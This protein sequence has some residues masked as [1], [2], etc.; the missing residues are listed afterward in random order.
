[1]TDGKIYINEISNPEIINR[2]IVINTENLLVHQKLLWP[3][4]RYTVTITCNLKKK[5]NPFEQVVLEL[6][7]SVTCDSERISNMTGINI[8]MVK[9][10]QQILKTKAFL[11]DAKKITEDGN[12]VLKQDEENIEEHFF[13]VYQEAYTGELLQVIEEATQ[14]NLNSGEIWEHRAINVQLYDSDSKQNEKTKEETDNTKENIRHFY[15]SPSK[16]TVG[17]ETNENQLIYAIR[18]PSYADAMCKSSV[19]PEK[20]INLI[21]GLRLHGKI[22][23]E[24]VSGIRINS[25]CD[26]VLVLT[27]YGIDNTNTRRD[28]LT[29]GFDKEWSPTMAKALSMV[30]EFDNKYLMKIRKEAETNSID[31]SSKNDSEK[32]KELKNRWWFNAQIKNRLVR[33]CDI[34]ENYKIDTIGNKTDVKYLYNNSKELIVNL[35]EVLQYAFCQAGKD[36][37]RYAA[38]RNEIESFVDNYYIKNQSLRNLKDCGFELDDKEILKRLPSSAEN[39]KKSFDDENSIALWCCV[40]F[41]ALECKQNDTRETHVLKKLSSQNPL[42]I[43]TILRIDE[44]RNAYQ[45]T[46]SNSKPLNDEEVQTYY[47]GTVKIISVLLPKK[48][49]DP[50]SGILVNVKDTE[51]KKTNSAYTEKLYKAHNK[52]Q[53][54]FGRQVFSMIP[55]DVFSELENTQMYFDEDEIDGQLYFSLSIILQSLFFKL[56]L[57]QP[58]EYKSLYEKECEEIKKRVLDEAKKLGFKAESN[59]FDKLLRTAPNRIRNTYMR[60]KDITLGASCITWL[61]TAER[62]EKAKIARR[63]PELLQ[64]TNRLVELRGHN[65]KSD[66]VCTKEELLHLRE[67]VFLFVKYLVVNGQLVD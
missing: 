44:L 59:V 18:Y 32:I 66:I 64:V 12:I 33:A 63:I 5:L 25:P 8:D 30:S 67:N 52:L 22:T 9:F 54:F 51:H 53:Q 58:Y 19:T 4:W 49:I 62:E 60:R 36:S 6:S 3:C 7:K 42:A 56:F 34:L 29:N 48:Q 15:K 10:T 35:Y 14:E 43:K 16:A 17:D 28:N 41:C 11:D 1:M 26:A 61:Y 37:V 65:G 39:I 21:N 31:L 23:M 13:V 46:Y 38:T 47:D 27:N 55:D 40:A 57:I 2:Q 50:K 45:H 24:K 20:I